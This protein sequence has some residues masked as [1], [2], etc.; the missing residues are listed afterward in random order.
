MPELV[1]SDG[2]FS[3]TP[4]ERARVDMTELCCPSVEVTNDVVACCSEERRDGEVIIPGIVC[5]MVVVKTPKE[6]SL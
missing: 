1:I 2:I 6:T 4:G 3:V 5:E